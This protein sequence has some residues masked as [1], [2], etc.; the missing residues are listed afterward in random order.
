MY[1]AGEFSMKKTVISESG[2]LFPAKWLSNLTHK[3]SDQDREAHMQ[4]D[5]TAFCL[6]MAPIARLL[7]SFKR[8]RDGKRQRIVRGLILAKQFTD[9]PPIFLPFSLSIFNDRASAAGKGEDIQSIISRLLL[10]HCLPVRGRERNARA[11]HGQDVADRSR[12]GI[13]L[14][15]ATTNQNRGIAAGLW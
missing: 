14:R 15:S 12:S 10:M 8:A 5:D 3:T 1:D 11:A 6:R 2:S 7:F 9:D 4:A 13:V